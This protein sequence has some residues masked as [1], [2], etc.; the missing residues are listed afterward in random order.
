MRAGEQIKEKY[1]N[2][3]HLKTT[4][5]NHEIFGVHIW[6]H[7]YICI[8]NMKFLC[9]TLWQGEVCT[10]DADADDANDGQS[11]IV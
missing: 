3:C 6:G 9:L 5:Q 8:P 10:D 7:M 4:S 1:Q 2:G 11:M